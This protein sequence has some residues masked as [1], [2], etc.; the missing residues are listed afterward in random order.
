MSHQQE[1]EPRQ[2]WV[3]EQKLLRHLEQV[4][5]MLLRQVA[6]GPHT[7]MPNRASGTME[8]AF[9]HAMVKQS[10]RLTV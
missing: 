7:L 3:K 6:V 4:Q 2:E 5:L 8:R 10:D 1:Q 9:D